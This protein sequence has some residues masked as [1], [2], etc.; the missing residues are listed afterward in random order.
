MPNQNLIEKLPENDTPHEVVW[1]TDKEDREARPPITRVRVRWLA[2]PP[3]ELELTA[4]YVCGT[5][6]HLVS[7]R[8]VDKRDARRNLAYALEQHYTKHHPADKAL[9][10]NQAQ[11]LIARKG[12]K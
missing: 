10:N 4:Q 3:R 11:E 6:E 5:S 9:R 7:V 2:G 12:V 1:Y 8:G